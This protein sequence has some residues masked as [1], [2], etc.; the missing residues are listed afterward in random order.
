MSKGNDNLTQEKITAFIEFQ[1]SV[2]S[3][4]QLNELIPEE[5]EYARL[6]HLVA[7]HLENSYQQM[8]KAGCFNPSNQN[9]GDPQPR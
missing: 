1:K 2:E 6:L 7:H 4:S 8:I 5:G 3:V 9:R